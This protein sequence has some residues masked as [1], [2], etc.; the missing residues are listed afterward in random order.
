[1][2][3]GSGKCEQACE[4]VASLP[5]PEKLRH[6]ISTQ[7]TLHEENSPS[8]VGLLCGPYKDNP[9]DFHTVVHKLSDLVLDGV[10][11]EDFRTPSPDSHDTKAKRQKN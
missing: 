10:S 5:S 8:A 7:G 2:T 1:M 3:G 4:P 6:R 11:W 9:V